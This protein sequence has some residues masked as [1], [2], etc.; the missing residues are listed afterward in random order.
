M[1]VYPSGVLS[2]TPIVQL[3][4]SPFF[5]SGAP[6]NI[7]TSQLPSSTC[8][9]LSFGWWWS[10]SIKNSQDKDSCFA[11]GFT[12]VDV[13]PTD[14]YILLLFLGR[15][16]VASKNP[17]NI[18][19]EVLKL[20][21]VGESS[22][23]CLHL[24]SV[25][26]CYVLLLEVSLTRF[27]KGLQK[28]PCSSCTCC[29]GRLVSSDPDGRWYGILTRDTKLSWFTGSLRLAIISESFFLGDTEILIYKRS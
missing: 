16:S 27:F 3:W 9:L 26:S 7:A 11:T 5:L 1:C 12:N 6:F 21:V 28:L 19:G 23:R 29:H 22:V 4:N 8:Q 15:E 25:K 14:F 24:D 17:R 18:W 10:S 2:P 13:F 20:K